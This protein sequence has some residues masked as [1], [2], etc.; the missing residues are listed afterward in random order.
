MFRET[1]CFTCKYSKRACKTIKM[2][3]QVAEF[4]AKERVS[5]FDRPQTYILTAI[6]ISEFK[7]GSTTPGEVSLVSIVYPSRV[8]VGLET[9]KRGYVNEYD[10]IVKHLQNV[11]EA[12][13]LN[14]PIVLQGSCGTGLAYLHMREFIKRELP[15][16]IILP[17]R[18]V[19]NE[20]LLK[21]TQDR[22]WTVGI[23]AQIISSDTFTFCNFHK[24][25]NQLLRWNEPRV[26]NGVR[27]E[28]PENNQLR[29]PTAVYREDMAL[30]FQRA[31][32]EP[33]LYMALNNF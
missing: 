31:L 9:V 24:L 2:S 16:I 19:T 10:L 28:L 5:V 20:E 29:P 18:S 3:F 7:N 21:S 25:E 12:P 22:L 4:L 27:I 8:L 33:T 32:H 11:R 26:P 15:G 30:A 14:L 17:E 1:S 13:G 23:A 6:E